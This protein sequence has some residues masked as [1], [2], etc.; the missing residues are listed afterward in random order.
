MDAD[1]WAFPD[2]FE[3]QLNFIESKPHVALVGTQ[4]FW[5]KDINFLPKDGWTYPTANNYLRLYLLFGASFGHSSVVLRSKTFISNNLRY[6]ETIKTCEDWDLWIRVS[7]VAEIN[8]LPDFLMKY[9]IVSNSNH[10]SVENKIIHLQERSAIISSYWQNFN[11]DLTPHQIFEFYYNNDIAEKANFNE[12]LGTIVNTFNHLFLNHAHPLNFKDKGMLSY[13]LIRKVLD[14][15][16][17][18]NISRYN[19]STWFLLL[20]K[21]RFINKFRLIK[22]LIR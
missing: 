4:G 14:F 9:R 10:R 12:N 3:K 11:V 1:D 7:K 18:S 19:L 21:V 17:R 5:L 22:S 13:M 20:L 6:N 2:R 8:N 15:W 16:K